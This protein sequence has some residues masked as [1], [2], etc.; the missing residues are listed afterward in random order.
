MTMCLV[1]ATATPTY[2]L[3][4]SE[5]GKSTTGT[6]KG[7][8]I[9]I[10]EPGAT[11]L[12]EEAEGGWKIPKATEAETLTFNVTAWKKCK[13]FS[14]GVSI[15]PCELSLKTT[16]KLSGKSLFSI[17]S[18]CKIKGEPIFGDPCTIEI[19]PAANGNLKETATKNEGVKLL[20]D[21]DVSGIT[22]VASGAGCIIIKEPKNKT[23]EI[24]GFM[25]VISLKET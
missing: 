19:E 5:N 25:D 10:S 14:V 11:A 24:K 9:T 22:S 23:G 18:T 17:L 12:C 1:A 2:A 6:G 15:S 21:N 7:E 3:F 20:A 13:A 8:N 16:A 4:T